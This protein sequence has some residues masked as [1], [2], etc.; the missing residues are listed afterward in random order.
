MT[1]FIFCSWDAGVT[2]CVPCECFSSASRNPWQ[3]QYISLPKWR[4]TKYSWYSKGQSARS[5]LSTKGLLCSASGEANVGSDFS[6]LR[7]NMC[8]RQ[9]LSLHK[10]MS[11]L[12]TI[13]PH[14]FFL[15]SFVKQNPLCSTTSIWYN[16]E[17]RSTVELIPYYQHFLEFLSPQ[18]R[19]VSPSSGS[20]FN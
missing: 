19:I 1:T 11:C 6:L 9:I 13:F 8:S 12:L 15:L 17:I 3:G 5:L 20:L 7:H 14:H 4:V 2:F 18:S 16:T 10:L